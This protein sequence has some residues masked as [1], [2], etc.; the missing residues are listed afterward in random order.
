MEK[1]FNL[2]AQIKCNVQGEGKTVRT[3]TKKQKERKKEKSKYF[4][5]LLRTSTEL[6]T[7]ENTSPEKKDTVLKCVFVCVRK[8]LSMS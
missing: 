7:F 5:K 6:L 4:K 1:Q 2:L 8:K 3:C